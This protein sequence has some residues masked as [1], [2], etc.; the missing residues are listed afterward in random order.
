MNEKSL[1]VLETNTTFF[2]KI[3]TSI[4][5]LFIPTKVGIN[6]ML[7]TMK[8]NNVLK[9][10]DIYRN[11][12]DIEDAKKKDVITQKY[13]DA[14]ALYLEAIDKYIM[15][16]VYT[17]VK[18]NNASDFEEKALSKYYEVTCLKE[19]EY[20]EYKYRKQK[21]LL[22]LD[23][24]S[25]KENKKAKDKY[26][27]FYITKMDALYKALLKNYS[28]QLSDHIHSNSQYR[29]KIYEK[30]FDTL[31]DYIA[32]I[33]P[34]KLETN[35]E[36]KTYQTIMK[37]YEEYERFTVGKLDQKETIERNMILL[38]ISRQLFT[39]SL[40]LIAAE[41]CYI[42][43]LKQTRQLIINDK[44]KEKQENAYKMLIRLIEDY[45]VRLLSTK[46]YWDKPQEKEEYKKF[47]DSYKNVKNEQEKEILFMKNDIIKL[48]QGKQD[49]SQIIKFYKDKLTSYGA[50]KSMKNT[51][52]TLTGRFIKNERSIRN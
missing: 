10:Y 20:L 36:D 19:S 5:K 42:N 46:I 7:I 11:M 35:T 16:S 33:L 32:N 48:R 27:G 15:D 25:I 31:K 40:P 45:N 41:Q 4:T 8:R 3:T 49:Y 30:I 18:N 29:S 52:K 22:E 21:Y 44:T 9:S 28:I 51:G 6:S 50:M 24:E 34:I 39:H 37:D 38:G 12:K 47:W 26:V 17:K 2:S 23:Y 13:E 1:K 14:Y 43:L